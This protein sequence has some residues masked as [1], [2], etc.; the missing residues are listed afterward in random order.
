MIEFMSLTSKSGGFPAARV[1]SEGRK[2]EREE[3]PLVLLRLIFVMAKK[4][5]SDNHMKHT[6]IKDISFAYIF[7]YIYF[8]C[9]A[10]APTLSCC[11]I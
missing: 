9:A 5:Q 4:T 1:R 2:L 3:T 7:I 10:A 6:Q 11:Y 8:G